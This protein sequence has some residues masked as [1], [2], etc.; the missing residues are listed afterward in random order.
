MSDQALERLLA[1]APKPDLRMM[2]RAHQLS[3]PRS[4]SDFVRQLAERQ[5]DPHVVQETLEALPPLTREIYAHVRETGGQASVVSLQREFVRARAARWPHAR[6][7]A[8]VFRGALWP[9][10]QFGLLLP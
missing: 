4:K 10:L 2:A 9:L 3:E 7:P 6:L 5:C 8:S 1:E